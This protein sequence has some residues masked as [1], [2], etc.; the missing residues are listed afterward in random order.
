MILWDGS[1]GPSVPFDADCI[2]KV[3]NRGCKNAME[4]LINSDIMVRASRVLCEVH[5]SGTL[6]EVDCDRH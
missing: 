2:A 6:L 3:A 1:P 5:E 4:P